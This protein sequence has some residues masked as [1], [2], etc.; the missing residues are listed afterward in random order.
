MGN[1]NIH[2][3]RADVQYIINAE[4]VYLE[5]KRSGSKF[6][7]LPRNPNFAGRKRELDELHKLLNEKSRV[8]ITQVAAQ[9]RGGIGKSALALE[10]AYRFREEYPG[11][12]YWITA[13]GSD[14][15]AEIAKLWTPLGLTIKPDEEKDTRWV[16]R[17]VKD[18]LQGGELFL[19]I[20]DNVIHPEGCTH[21]EWQKVLPTGDMCRFLLTT[22]LPS[23]TYATT[24]SLDILTPDDAL[25][26]FGKLRALHSEEDQKAAEGIVSRLGYLA[27]IIEICGLYLAKHPD[28]KLAD[29]LQRLENE[30]LEAMDAAGK[31]VRLYHYQ[32]TIISKVLTEPLETLSGEARFVLECAAFMPPDMVPIPW[33]E[34]ALTKEFP[35][36]AGVVKP[37]Y[38]DFKTGVIEELTGLRLLTPGGHD[39]LLQMHRL[40]QEAARKFS[41]DVSEARLNLVSKIA[42]ERAEKLGRS[43]VDKENRW[44]LE[45]LSAL[46]E[47][48]H[49][50][51]RN[52]IGLGLANIL[53]TPFGELARFSEGKVLLE[54]GLKLVAE[55]EQPGK[56]A[57]ACSNL[58]SMEQNLG[59]FSRA[60]M[61]IEK[62]I[63]SKKYVDSEML[64]SFYSNFALIE[65]DLENPLHARELLQKAI[66][67]LKQQYNPDILHLAV[68]YSNL[69]TIETD[70]W[71]LPTARELIE[72]AIRIGEENL[73]PNHPTLAVR[74]ANLANILLK[75]DEKQEA[76]SNWR[77]AHKIYQDRLGLGHP[78]TKALEEI[79]LRYCND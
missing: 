30:G 4:K 3:P 71:N 41:E 68:L 56:V 65:K 63:A 37:G 46:V 64:I 12:V 31:E 28:I 16:V 42:E 55:F 1:Q 33:L 2:D 24:Y 9:G 60:R 35:K 36:L 78:R 26:L 22:K 53:A 74:Y 47:I 6:W 13:S 23:L 5:Q 70:L 18:A 29:Y 66:S 44:E 7:L 43:W 20:F 34:D 79:L 51:D 11:G 67:N 45:P 25:N 52:L 77:K 17:R 49:S 8:G 50:L 38:P 62:A 54:Q 58:A 15:T 73:E 59:N 76:C 72:E 57:V 69:A 48:Y 40:L 14:I 19:L 32:E 10:Y 75:Q 39:Q 61:H 27:L 21:P